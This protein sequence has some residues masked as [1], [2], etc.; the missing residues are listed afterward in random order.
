LEVYDLFNLSAQ[1]VLDIEVVGEV[2]V[3]NGITPDGDGK[4]DFFY[5][6]YLNV[7]QG[8][9]KNKVTIFNRWGDIVFDMSDYNNVDRVFTGLS[10]QG[11]QLPPGTYFYRIDLS[12]SK[13]VTGYLTLKR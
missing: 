6:Q 3:F 8:G 1:R 7:V 13:P 5:I 2:I 10:N 9:L 11:S 12:D 4:N